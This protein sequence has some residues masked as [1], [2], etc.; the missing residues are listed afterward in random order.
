[1]NTRLVPA[2]FA[3]AALFLPFA[4]CSFEVDTEGGDVVDGWWRSALLRWR[5]HRAY[6]S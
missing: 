5:W 3:C 2:L 6:R 1:M 4:G